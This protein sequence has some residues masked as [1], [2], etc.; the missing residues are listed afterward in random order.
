MSSANPRSDPHAVR[1]RDDETVA[2]AVELD[3]ALV[4]LTPTRLIVADR[5]R[6]RLDLPIEQRRR[7]Q[8]TVKS[9]R[10][11]RITFVPTTD[12]PPADPVVVPRERFEETGQ[13]VMAIGR[14]VAGTR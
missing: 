11:G 2:G 3:D 6:L 9:G 5:R 12:R 14:I 10:P 1:V 8:L 4:S 7:G 13:A